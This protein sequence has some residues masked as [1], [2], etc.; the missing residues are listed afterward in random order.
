RRMRDPAVQRDGFMLRDPAIQGWEV[1]NGVQA[2]GSRDDP[3]VQRGL[4]GDRTRVESGMSEGVPV[5]PLPA[6]VT[7][8]RRGEDLYLSIN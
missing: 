1:R 5:S 6:M 3:A 7:P 2:R 4:G 8:T